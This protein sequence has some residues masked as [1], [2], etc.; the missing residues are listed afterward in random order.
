MPYYAGGS[1][2]TK[3]WF[4]PAFLLR[5]PRRHKPSSESHSSIYV[6]QAQEK[7]LQSA[8]PRTAEFILVVIINTSYQKL[9]FGSGDYP[10]KLLYHQAQNY[11]YFVSKFL[12]HQTGNY[13]V[14]FRFTTVYKELPWKCCPSSTRV[15]KS[16]LRLRGL[17]RQALTTVLVV[18]SCRP[19]CDNA[20]KQA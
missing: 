3:F 12:T 9:P 11:P 8:L 18:R 14:M 7:S 5:T 1:Q 19:E 16:Y 10:D 17:P 6:P 20:R 2:I 13:P 15:T 4:G